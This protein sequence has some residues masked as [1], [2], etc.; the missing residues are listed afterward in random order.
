LAPSRTQAPIP[1][2]EKAQGETVKRVCIVSASRDA[3]GLVR[4]LKALEDLGETLLVRDA[5]AETA[6]AA[7][8]LP[9]PA[10]IAAIQERAWAFGAAWALPHRVDEFLFVSGDVLAKRAALADDIRLALQ[11]VPADSL[12]VVGGNGFL[13]VPRDVLLRFDA[14]F[15]G[16]V[17]LVEALNRSEGTVART[18]P[19]D[20]LRKAEP[21]SRRTQFEVS[22]Q[23]P[24]PVS[25][26]RALPDASYPPETVR[27]SL[28]MIA[29]NEEGRL[30]RCL[31]SVRDLVDEMIVV[32]TGS[33]DRTA[34][35][36][37]QCGAVVRH[38]P[39]V[40]DFSAARNETLKYATGN[41]ILWLDADEFLDESNRERL[42]ILKKSL[43]R[44][45]YYAMKQASKTSHGKGADLVVDQIRLFPFL[46]GVGWTLR[47]HE[48][49]SPSLAPHRL[50]FVI[51]DIHVE[52][53]GFADPSKM[54]GKVQ[55]NHA[56]L[57]KD[58]DEHPNNAFVRFNLGASFLDL[59]RS[60]E[61]QE[62]FETALALSTP[63][64]SYRPKCFVY[65]AKA[66]QKQRKWAEAARCC[67]QGRTEYP[68]FGELWHE[69]G[70]C[71]QM[72]GDRSAAK[73]CWEQALQTKSDVLFAGGDPAIGGYRTRVMLANLCRD[74]GNLVE[75]ETHW[76]TAILQNP[77][78]LRVWSAI[79][80]L[81]L[82]Q[83]RFDELE[84]LLRRWPTEGA[85]LVPMYHARREALIGKV[86]E[87]RWR[88]E[89]AIAQHPTAAYLKIFL[90][91][92]LAEHRQDLPFAER[93]IVEALRL[94]PRHGRALK[95]QERLARLQAVAS[96]IGA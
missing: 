5:S 92:M 1:E 62:A 86:A 90:A 75:A 26:E 70:I 72:L 51:T 66:F 56:L 36:A 50:H 67:E 35:V 53:D 83:R 12:R 33:T 27:L 2:T 21:K 16:T 46:E 79:A 13:A 84:D 14:W 22:H 76:R 19:R 85:S 89:A 49:V 40:D 78:L 74:L 41:W 91:E 44:D 15:A 77:S 94:E 18:L 38:F 69:E 30:G 58:R 28:C 88:I 32:D 24:R 65:L 71:R 42:A 10:Q 54:R 55:R 4:G 23:E 17:T 20:A 59:G 48:Q 47:V 61:A 52:H 60:T 80:D 43:R 39:W 11:S 37:R 82:E 93:L 3:S 8:E 31:H 29:R 45:C 95:L 25:M 68:R 96:D 7:N 63:N 64:E 73:R 87:A 34:E 9:L 57:V 6:G 81:L